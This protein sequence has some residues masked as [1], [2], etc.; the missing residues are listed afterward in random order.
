[1]RRLGW[2]VTLAFLLSLPFRI[3]YPQ[4]S[5]ATVNGT[6]HDQ[7][8]AVITGAKLTLTNTATGTRVETTS[9]EA[10]IYVFPGVIPGPY[11]LEAQSPGMERYEATLVVDVAQKVTV[12]PL[13]KPGSTSITVEVQDVTPMVNLT[14]STDS[15]VIE[16]QDID[17]MPRFG[18]Q[19]SSIQDLIPGMNGT[20]QADG[21]RYGSTDW[22][23]DGAP[24]VSR[25]RG[26]IENRQPGIDSIQEL[27]VDTNNVSA[28]YNSPVA[29]IMSTKSGANGLHGSLFETI[30]NSGIYYARQRNQG[31]ASPAY[32]NRNEFG[33]SAGGPV[34]IPKVYNGKDKTFWFF[35]WESRRQL[36]NSYVSSGYSVPTAAMRAGDFSGLVNSN[37]I[38][39]RIY[40]PWTTAY[41]AAAKIY[42]RQQFN[43]G[44]KLNAIDPAKA[45]PLWTYLMKIT[46]MPTLPNVNPLISSNWYGNAVTKW[47]DDTYSAR[48]DHHF[49]PRDLFYARYS[50]NDM[51]ND[52]PFS[53]DVPAL[54]NDTNRN[55]YT[56]PAQSLATSYVHIVSPTLFNELLV[57]V[58]RQ[59][60]YQSSNPTTPT[61]YAAMLGLPNPY[62]G[63]Q[64]PDVMTIG[65]TGSQ[66][67]TV[68]PNAD[69]ST[70]FQ[71]NDNVTKMLGKHQLMAG[72]HFR[73]DLIN[74]LPQQERAAGQVTPVANWT[75]LWNPAGSAGSPSATTYTG[76]TVASSFL[77]LNSYEAET[78]H[79]YFYE[80]QNQYALYLQD[81][82]KIT[83][84][85]SL[86][87]GLRWEAWPAMQ[88]KYNN[89]VGFD[90]AQ[91]AFVLTQSA[92]EYDRLVPGFA[93]NVSIMQ[94]LGVKFMDYKQA[95]LPRSLQYGNWKDFSPRV[96][97]AYRV[98][99]GNR[100]LVLRSGFTIAYYPIQ[101]YYE[102]EQM[103]AGGPYYSLPLYSP[104]SAG[105]YPDGAPGYS[106]RSVPVYVAGV[107]TTHIL[108]NA[109]VSGLT[110]GSL[111]VSYMDPHSP[112]SRVADGNITL[113]K[114][115]LSKTVLRVAWV[116]NHNWNVDTVRNINPATP[117]F[118]WVSNTHTS[119]PS[120]A[121]ATR[122]Y[123]SLLGDVQDITRS[124][125]SNYSG[126]HVELEHRFTSG[127]SYRMFYVSNNA[128][129]LG[130][131]N[132]QGTSTTLYPASYY[133][134]SQ[135]SGLT[136]DQLD[137]QINYARNTT[138]PHRQ[139]SWNW[140][141]QIPV[142]RGKRL[143]GNA[144]PWMNAV[145]GGWQLSGIGKW[146]T[147]WWSLQSGQ[148][149]TGAKL[150]IWGHKYHVEDCRSGSC[151]S[152]YLYSNGGWINPA[153]INSHN[154]AGQCTGICGIPDGYKSFSAP[155]V[156]DP[157]SPYFGTNTVSL[158]LSS[159]TNYIGSW[160]GLSPLN[161]Q[162]FESPGLWT[163]SASL[164][165]EVSVRERARL[166]VQWDVSN[167]TN[168]PEEAQIPNA[169]GL[170]YSYTSGVAARSM[171]LSLR[172][173]W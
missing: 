49:S 107:N 47:N 163:L 160:G 128:Y 11:R 82:Y 19:I 71:V 170:I 158:P 25:S 33:A 2:F 129:S 67:R 39:L 79:K 109:T 103:R 138:F 44:G 122:P 143:L 92:Q 87:L 83:R 42:T 155:L 85:M 131:I 152:A 125:Y 34:Y 137:R 77:G 126:I 84:K 52:T 7:T 150:Q 133:L 20:Y 63:K 10:G 72:V 140:V 161:N 123:S 88:E 115:I 5:T 141:A 8:N 169:Y 113:E 9:N 22:S 112:D 164:F 93:S 55:A 64:W 66:W 167:P 73:R 153:Q 31:N 111:K 58:F 117:T 59:A 96:G 18:R 106:L 98:T 97:F 90:P 148:F 102:L 6:V 13:L 50:K 24:L 28:K 16:N 168:S 29:I 80:R 136:Q 27:T 114:Q 68:Y 74:Y 17:Q 15:H 173:L 95:G 69:H 108:D 172:L 119:L 156:T 57:S 43:Y 65:L 135:V 3:A 35:S 101:I 1:M 32:S 118:V 132:N 124:A 86:S 94:N 48:F 146:S 78:V 142:G 165:K 121:G 75:A 70:F 157:T 36:S 147:S 81:N 134:P 62:G 120:G 104:D 130:V 91:K 171:Q 162:I 45:S 100:P 105:Y 99:G 26:T 30:A 139:L 40:D 149:P 54:T 89:T 56:S 159:G 23:L 110:A 53:G 41:D 46:P 4:A 116:A 60:F 61:D 38:Q 12:D 37:G 76:S 151:L 145:V 127:Y 166:R 154:A 14:D 144:G 21:L 51:I